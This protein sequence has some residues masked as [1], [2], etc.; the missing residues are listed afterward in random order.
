MT[1]SSTTSS[2]ILN[3]DGSTHNFSF[4]FKILSSSDLKVIVR[5]TAGVETEKTLN[6]QYIIPSSSVG[7][8]SGGN[9]LFKYNTGTSGD[10][11]YSATDYRPANG[12]KVILRRQPVQEQQLNLVN[13]DPFNAE[14]IEESLDKLTMQVQAVQ[15]EVDRT[16]RLSRTNIL[17]KDGAQINNAFF[18]LSD[19]VATRK[20][21]FL[22]FNTTTGVIEPSATSDDVTT[23]AAVTTDIALLAD[24]QDGTS[25]T[26]TLTVVS[27]ISGN[28]TTCASISSDITSCATIS[29]NI[30]TVAGKASLI[31]SDFATDMALIDSTFVTNMNLVTSDFVSDVNLITSDFISD[32]SLVTADFV[33]DVNTLAT[34]D[35]VSDL[36]TLA[37]SAIVDDMNLLATSSNVTAMANLGVSSV[38]TNMANLNASGVITNIGTVAGSISNVNTV[39]AANSNI[40]TVASAN[41]NIST[42]ASANSNISTVATNISGVN[43]FAERY[44]VASSAPSSSLDAG[45]LY[46]NT[47]T[48]KLNVYSGSSWATTGEAAQR[49]VTTHTVTSAGTQ[50]ISVS[51]T[52]GL[53]AV[54]LN[55]L[56]L[57]G[58]DYTASNGSSVVITGCS[59]DDVIDIV[60]LS[61]FN[62]A[63]YGTASGKNIG[64]GNDNVP[65]FGSS[66]ASD[67]DFLK[68][69]GTSVE[70]RSASEVLS[71]IGAQA[72]LTFG[73]AN[74][75][76]VKIDHASVTSADY[77]K[78]TS[79]GIEGRSTSEV[80]SDIGGL[81][82]S[83]ASSTYAPLAGATFTG[84]ITA[85]GGINEDH[86]NGALTNSNQ[87]LTLD[88]HDGN[89]FSVTTAA[90]ITSFVVS[91]LPASGTA[92]FF[93]LKVTFGGSHSITWGS[94][95]KWASATAPT[96]S[97]SGTDIFSFYTIDS[98]TTIYGVVSGQ[99]LA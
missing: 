4:N 24:I 1:I 66:G 17:D 91:N 76:A 7:Q 6:S 96:L 54:Y 69:D 27:G 58:A 99:A 42:V 93:T 9:V 37:T 19:D 90:S 23:L 64:I 80:L 83:V 74:T 51:Y 14:L 32:M 86:N 72:S 33:A 29:S 88:A 79:S 40:S 85:N 81:S 16:F 2:V 77:A 68:I 50:T 56:H 41:S 97:T 13:N 48:N 87:T 8:D 65:V 49:S 38:I 43:S 44:R 22:Q 62:A 31:T 82:T 15:E 89:N 73:I 47:S 70:G 10:A 26:N 30:T 20:G 67:N 61:A 35:I 57:S 12:E 55:G 45:D 36:N 92:F 5:S 60:A 78:F 46:F 21:K 34:S 84:E 75:N 25:A 53:L 28:V 3:A 11:H 52:V 63:N 18:Q 59:V 71:D 95:V 94:A 39:A 98:G